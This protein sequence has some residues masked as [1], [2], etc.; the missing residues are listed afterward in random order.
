MSAWP[1]N[2]RFFTTSLIDCINIRGH[3]GYLSIWKWQESAE[4][5]RWSQ[6]L[7]NQHKLDHHFIHSC[8]VHAHGG[9]SNPWLSSIRLRII[10]WITPKMFFTRSVS[11]AVV[12]KSY[13]S[14]F[15]CLFLFKYCLFIYSLKWKYLWKQLVEWFENLTMPA[16][17]HLVLRSLADSRQVYD[18]SASLG[19]GR[20]CWRRQWREFS[21]RRWSWGSRRRVSGFPSFCLCCRPHR[22]SGWSRSG[23]WWR[24]LQREDDDLKWF[25][26]INRKGGS[27]KIWTCSDIVKALDPLF[28]LTAL[29]SHIH[30]LK[31]QLRRLYNEFR[32]SSK[33][34]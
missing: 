29:P 22:A 32:T 2:I 16:Q 28:P 11:V 30:Q 8:T 23:R 1:S 15:G 13:M 24:G 14:R 20:L 18:L 19:R 10:S 26:I 4:N 31:L 7:K 3:R 5:A 17:S 33:K 12:V 34:F 21:G 25:K 6:A 27:W 9:H